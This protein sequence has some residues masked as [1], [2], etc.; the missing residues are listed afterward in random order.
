[1]PQMT[2]FEHTPPRERSGME[3]PKCGSGTRVARNTNYL[4][5]IV[6]ERVCR[7]ERC[8]HVFTTTERRDDAAVGRDR[9]A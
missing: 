4:S 9:A 5:F 3:C 7:N 6:R 8:R 2:L 1:M